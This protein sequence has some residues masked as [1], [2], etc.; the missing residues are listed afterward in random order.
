MSDATEQEL[1]TVLREVKKQNGPNWKKP[2]WWGSWL[3]IITVGCSAVFFVGNLV[4]ERK[5]EVFL[6][7]R[8]AGS[9]TNEKTITGVSLATLKEQN[10]KTAAAVE[11]AVDKLETIARVIDSMHSPRTQ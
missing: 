6:K 7:E 11:R 8:G 4:L 9:Y 3:T 5:L 2:G 10:A 1:L